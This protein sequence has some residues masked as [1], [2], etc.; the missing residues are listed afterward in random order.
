MR[1]YVNPFDVNNFAV[2]LVVGASPAAAANYVGAVPVNAR[3]Q[4]SL[5][6]CQLVADANVANRFI[7]IQ[8]HRGANVYVLGHSF[9]AHVATNTLKYLAF[10]GA[11]APFSTVND[12]YLFNLPDVPMF[13]ENDTVRIVVVNIQA[14]DQLSAIRLIWKTWPYEQ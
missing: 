12:S 9:T 6:S 10:A 8:L 14:A 13:L 11:G 1:P 4:L 3:S 2:E 7:E 5:L